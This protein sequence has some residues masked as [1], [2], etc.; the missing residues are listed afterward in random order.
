M[1]TFFQ[2]YIDIT[3]NMEKYITNKNRIYRIAHTSRQKTH[4]LHH[5]FYKLF[6]E[7]CNHTLLPKESWKLLDDYQEYHQYLIDINHALFNDT[8]YQHQLK[9]AYDLDEAVGKEEQTPSH[10]IQDT[11]HTND[12]NSTFFVKSG[13]YCK[14]MRYSRHWIPETGEKMVEYEVFDKLMEILIQEQL[15]QM[16]P[17]SISKIIRFYSH[18]PNNDE[19]NIYLEMERVG[20][21]T[22]DEYIRKRL[23]ATLRA[24]E[25]TEKKRYV[26]EICQKLIVVARTLDT[27]QK[28]CGL[29]HGDF[30]GSNLLI[31]EKNENHIYLID[32]EFSY[33]KQKWNQCEYHLYGQENFLLEG[34]YQKE[35]EENQNNYLLDFVKSYSSPYAYA[36]DL[37]Y[38]FLAAFDYQDPTSRQILYPFFGKNFYYKLVPHRAPYEAFV[39]SKD[40]ILLAQICGKYQVDFES[41]ITQFYPEQVIQKLETLIQKMESE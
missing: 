23:I 36:S 29:I 9:L 16:V 33:I 7:K 26:K 6:Y 39:Y 40:F 25:E 15:Y 20:S 30:K 38:L 8:I 24:S 19:R 3:Q 18:T 27:F 35:E 34:R 17:S 1:S 32:F 10:L 37:L 4:M 21:I 31:D 22:L 41:F 5:L 28:K 13:A 14:K 2:E 11:K 12:R